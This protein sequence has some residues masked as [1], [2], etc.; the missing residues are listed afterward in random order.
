LRLLLDTHFVIWLATNQ[1]AIRP[2][3][4][5]ALNDSSNHVVASTISIWEVRVKWNALH[6]SGGRKGALD[7]L[8]AT[9]YL[10]SIGMEIIALDTDTAAAPLIISIAHK[11][12]FDEL[13]LVQAQQSG[14]RLLTRDRTLLS[15]P[16]AY[17]PL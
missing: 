8:L 16:L 6:A 10:G 14:A 12:P 2:S 9:S 5:R 15:H 13:L 4:W 7:P 3:E 17:Q 1:A 11:D